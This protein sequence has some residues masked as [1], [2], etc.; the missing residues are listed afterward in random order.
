MAFVCFV[1]FFLFLGGQYTKD[2]FKDFEKDLEN[3][4]K[5]ALK[6]KV[7]P[8]QE[9]PCVLIVLHVILHTLLGAIPSLIFTVKVDL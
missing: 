9:Y 3:R 2:D 4:S 5:F 8:K 6:D 7:K 1:G